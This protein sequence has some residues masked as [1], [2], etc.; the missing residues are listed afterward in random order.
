M[1]CPNCGEYHYFENEEKWCEVFIDKPLYI[2][3]KDADISNPPD[4]IEDIS[5]PTIYK[6][7]NPNAS[8]NLPK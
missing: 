8:W 3:L 1:K 7:R 2:E 5:W 6:I 4:W